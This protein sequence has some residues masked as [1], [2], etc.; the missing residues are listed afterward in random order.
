[1]VNAQYAMAQ[2]VS[3]LEMKNT[4]KFRP[5]MINRQ[6]LYLVEIVVDRP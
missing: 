3:L 2:V 6:T 4:R 5:G 1:M